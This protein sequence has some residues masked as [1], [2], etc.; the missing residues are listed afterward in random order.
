MI[1]GIQK[2]YTEISA[3]YERSNS[4]LTLGLDGRWR[5]KAVKSILA[6]HPGARCFLD[7]CSGTGQTAA[8]LSRH[9]QAQENFRIIAADFSHPMLRLARERSLRENLANIRFTLGDTV[10]LPFPDNTFDVI[11]ITFA[12]RNLAAAPGHL[13]ESFREFHRVLKPGGCFYNL[14]TSQPSSKLIKTFFHLYVK[15]TVAPLG[16]K[17]SGSKGSY[18]Y[19]SNSIRSFLPAREL[20]DALHEA[21]FK[22]VTWKNLLFGA[23][24]FHQAQK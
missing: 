5:K 1:K 23:V 20:A 4:L 14:E 15:L 6:S 13:S 24:A 22:T 16:R 9:L 2:I 17:I 8:M 18:V 11:V 21:G 7:I 3:S 12:T 19:L 10:N